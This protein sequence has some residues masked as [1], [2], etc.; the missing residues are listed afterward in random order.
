[1]T[2]AKAASCGPRQRLCQSLKHGVRT[3]VVSSPRQ[4]AA[5]AASGPGC[6]S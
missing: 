5:R 4:G 2:G 3:E 6:L 1:M